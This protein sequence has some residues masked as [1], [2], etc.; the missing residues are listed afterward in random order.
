MAK[1][2]VFP[3]V[4]LE[5]AEPSSAEIQREWNLTHVHPNYGPPLGKGW[6]R[7]TWLSERREFVKRREKW[8]RND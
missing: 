5:P 8:R 1:I 7:R 6:P 4:L 3:H 2:L